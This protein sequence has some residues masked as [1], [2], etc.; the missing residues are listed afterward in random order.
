[1]TRYLHAAHLISHSTQKMPQP[2]T[3]ITCSPPSSPRM[4]RAPRI[5]NLPTPTLP[6]S[7]LRD[8]I[9]F[10]QSKDADDEDGGCQ[11]K[12][13]ILAA[14]R[15]EAGNIRAT[16]YTRITRLV[17]TF[18]EDG[19]EGDAMVHKDAEREDISLIDAAEGIMGVIFDIKDRVMTN[20]EYLSLNNLCR[21]VYDGDPVITAGRGEDG[22]ERTVCRTSLKDLYE[23]VENA[24]AARMIHKKIIEK[25]DKGNLSSEAES[26]IE[27]LKAK[28]RVFMFRTYIFLQKVKDSAEHKRLMDLIHHCAFN[29]SYVSM[30]LNSK[31]RKRGDE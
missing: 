24:N 1:M 13:R 31:K 30:M 22:R 5:H 17:E 10:S 12:Q 3:C 25:G 15:R 7:S 23:F 4:S 6:A 11:A 27:N 28:H 2:S 18:V 19:A 14:I 16:E 29:L 9:K 20:D 26:E 8:K 21:T